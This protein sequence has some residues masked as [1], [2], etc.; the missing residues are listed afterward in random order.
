[1]SEYVVTPDGELRHYGVK[2]MKWGVRRAVRRDENVR[3]AR[4]QF[5]KDF[6]EAAKAARKTKS[7]AITER[8]KAKKQQR[9]EAYDKAYDKMQKSQQKLKAAESKARKSAEASLKKTKTTTKKKVSKNDKVSNAYKSQIAVNGFNAVASLLN[10]DAMSAAV[11]ARN[12][13]RYRKGLEY[14]N[15]I[16]S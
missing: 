16:M 3:K 8:G 1:M 9:A 11:Y 15:D 12:T 6:N 7:F 4:K 13:N 14:W 10:G 5:N 2:G